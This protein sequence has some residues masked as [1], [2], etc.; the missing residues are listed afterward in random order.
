MELICDISSKNYRATG[1]SLNKNMCS[2]QLKVKLLIN[3][4]I[5]QFKK[6]MTIVSTKIAVILIGSELFYIHK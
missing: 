1:G 2:D 5:F 3:L 6:N 4:N